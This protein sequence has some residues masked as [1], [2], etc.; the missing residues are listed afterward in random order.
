M[1]DLAI[2][3]TI[4]VELCSSKSFY[5][6]RSSIF[7]ASYFARKVHKWFTIYESFSFFW[8]EANQYLLSSRLKCFSFVRLLFAIVSNKIYPNYFWLLLL[9]LLLRLKWVMVFNL[10]LAMIELVSGNSICLID[11]WQLLLKDIVSFSRFSVFSTIR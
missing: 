5:Q 9:V 11:Y 1:A 4:F 10:L 6:P 8:S 7:K 3:W 2:V